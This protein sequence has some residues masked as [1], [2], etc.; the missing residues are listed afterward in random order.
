MSTERERFEVYA[1]SIWLSLSKGLEGDYN[2]R[3]TGLAYETWQH[4]AAI[5]ADLQ[6][7]LTE[8]NRELLDAR[9]QSSSLNRA[10]LALRDCQQQ[11]TEANRQIESYDRYI[12]ANRQNTITA[13]P[14]CPKM[15]ALQNKALT[16]GREGV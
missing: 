12:Q 7:Q 2:S 11:L 9:E 13:C 16:Q 3:E 6:Q 10:L 8:A 4:Q 1:K 15:I 14:E 5:I